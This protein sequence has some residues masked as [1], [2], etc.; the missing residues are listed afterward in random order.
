[1]PLDQAKECH[2]QQY[3]E[4]LYACRRPSTVV[5]ELSVIRTFYRCLVALGK[6]KGN[7]A[8]R[9]QVSLRDY[10]PRTRK[11]PLPAA[12]D[13]ISTG[14][15][16]AIRDR[17]IVRLRAVGLS[18]SQLVGLDVSDVNREAQLIQVRRRNGRMV[19]MYLDDAA[20]KDVG[21]WLAVQ[22][23]VKPLTPAVFV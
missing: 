18:T 4:S 22:E 11:P 8:R 23:L 16:V 20:W 2:L 7:P 10:K 6:V 12:V 5:K 1:V 3:I 9:I 19:N 13:G 15:M 21:R 17:A 14:T